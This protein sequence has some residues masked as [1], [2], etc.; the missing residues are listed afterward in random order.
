[1]SKAPSGRGPQA[2]GS[3]GRSRRRVAERE[4]GLRRR[5]WSSAGATIDFESDNG[6]F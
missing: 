2:R 3:S 4:G 6:D 5:V 1:M